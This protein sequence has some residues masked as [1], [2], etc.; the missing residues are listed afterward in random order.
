[1]E[2]VIRSV[3][4]SMYTRSTDIRCHF[5][6]RESTA[7]ETSSIHFVTDTNERPLI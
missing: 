5:L 1:M 7:A 6:R 2:F 3:A 4:S